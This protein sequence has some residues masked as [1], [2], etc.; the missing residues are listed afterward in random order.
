M[1]NKLL[2]FVGTTEYLE[3]YYSYE[4]FRTRLPCQFIQESLVEFFCTDWEREDQV[5]VFLTEK[6][7]QK[8]WKGKDEFP[9]AN[10]SEGLENRLKR[11]NELEASIKPVN[12]PECT[13]EEE[14]SEIFKIITGN[15]ESED[16]I[17]LDVTNAFRSIPML[18]FVSLNYAGVLRNAKIEKILYG[19]MESLGSTEEVKNIPVNNRIIPIFDLTRFVDLFDWT[20]GIE[21]FLETGNTRKLEELANK[22]LEPQLKESKGAEGGRYRVLVS[23]LCSFE[24]KISTCRGPKLKNTVEKIAASLDQVKDDKIEM[25][26]L[27]PLIRKVR[28]RFLS[29]DTEN[30]ISCGLDAVS[31]C[32]EHGLIQQG[33]TILR[34]TVVNFIIKEIFGCSDFQN[35]EYREKAEKLLNSE[36]E[37][38]L[39]DIL[40]LWG[41]IVQ[42]RNDIN[43]AG[44]KE[45][46]HKWKDFGM[47][48]KSFK[49]KA[50]SIF[51]HSYHV[52]P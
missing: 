23:L 20:L 26:M 37:G 21:R 24:G 34:E 22:E 17:F 44:W 14:F 5:V 1:S 52:L 31:W 42:Y 28:K 41:E 8:N 40:N 11:K 3:A 25:P 30:H 29:M 13:N 43:H 10:F 9:D 47:K 36:D 19:C 6:S 51:D 32:I 45:E 12:I 33:Y 35:Q 18:A 27:D 4:G 49:E 48:L 50:D 7:R 46:I 15:I 2:S 38:I 39:P 16:K